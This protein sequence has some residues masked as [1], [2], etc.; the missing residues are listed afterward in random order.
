V[1]TSAL[2]AEEA[3]VEKCVE[4]FDE[5]LE[6]QQMRQI[7]QHGANELMARF[8]RGELTKIELDN[9]LRV[10]HTVESELKEKVTALYDIAYK[11]KCFDEKLNESR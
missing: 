1:R 7:L 4:Y 11:K 10:W 3:A 8:D 6:T 5:I 9:T 2:K